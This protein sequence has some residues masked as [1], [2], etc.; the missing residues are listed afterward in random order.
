MIPS[1]IKIY[2]GL[3]LILYSGDILDIELVSKGASLDV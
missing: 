3:T 2:I 1:V